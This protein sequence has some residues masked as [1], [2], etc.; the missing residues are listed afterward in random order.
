MIIVVIV[1]AN[2]YCCDC[3]DEYEKTKI[4]FMNACCDNRENSCLM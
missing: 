1:M 4:V 2:D 3:C